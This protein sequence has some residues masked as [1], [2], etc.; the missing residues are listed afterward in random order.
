MIS[1]KIFTYI[2]DEEDIIESW[3]RYHKE[4]CGD[5][6]N[7]FIID[8]GSTD[9]TPEILEK[10]QQLGVNIY[11]HSDYKKKGIYLSKIMNENKDNTKFLVPIDGD[12]FV[13]LWRICDKFKFLME[14]YPHLL[15]K[16]IS[17]Y[18]DPT[19]NPKFYVNYYSDLKDQRFDENKALW[20]W[21]THGKSEGRFPNEIN[22]KYYQSIRNQSTNEILAQIDETQFNAE[23]LSQ[24][25]QL[26]KSHQSLS[27]NKSYGIC[28]DTSEIN[29]Y[30][31][32]LENKHGRF[33]FKFYLNSV[34]R[35]TDY[36]DPSMEM[37]EFSIGDS[38]R[39][40]KKFFSAA[41]FI[42]TDHGNHYGWIKDDRSYD[43]VSTD[44]AL[45]HY[46]ERGDKK[47]LQRVT[48]D[49]K[50]LG[51]M[52]SIPDMINLANRRNVTGWHNVDRYLRL[53]GHLP[54]IKPELWSADVKSNAM[55]TKINEI[56]KYN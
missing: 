5:Y 34:P 25:N 13:I 43:Y 54:P 48:N 17:T 36:V 51:N 52:K 49:V 9:K 41:R 39:L 46:H 21:N 44:L 12:E 28:A 6:S 55:I 45:I 16:I 10:Y 2:R 47:T 4:I 18:P 33:A 7:L 8:N 42:A 22:L 30:F 20:H 1:L 50:G 27:L 14:K 53:T 56:K 29:R 19:L 38:G 23:Q 15:N 3:I 24:L 35:K 40:N 37:D 31:R 32:K 11:K 26:Y